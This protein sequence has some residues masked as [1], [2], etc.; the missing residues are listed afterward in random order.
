MIGTLVNTMAIVIGSLF[1]LFFK[2]IFSDNIQKTVMHGLSLTVILI[3][4]Q[5]AFKTSDILIVIFSIVIGAII[6]EIINIEGHLAN[7][8]DK[9]KDKFNSDNDL[10]VQGFV[11]ASL[12]YCVGA[13]AI[14][15]AI[16]DGLNSDP[17]ILYNK[18][19]LDG[20]ASIAFSAT[21]GIGVIFSAVPVLLYQGGISMLA[22]WAE[23]FLTDPLI[24][25]MTA[26][27][28]LLIVAIGLNMVGATRIRVGNLLP[29]LL[30]AV[31]LAY[32][33]F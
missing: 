9:L 11:Q 29:S 22:S 5:M 30:V 18:S 20:I 6:G 3:G 33:M 2:N 13:M 10:F 16:Q 12:V 7:F 32:F 8:G 28:G 17:T 31:I 23:N 4:L 26:T 21:F 24:N 15:G 19:L 27:G 25:E 14:M 1:G